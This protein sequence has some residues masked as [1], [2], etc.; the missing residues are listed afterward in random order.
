MKERLRIIRIISVL[1]L[2]FTGINALVAGVLFMLDPSGKK[3]GMSTAYLS[4]S[5]FS[6]F[7]IPGCILFLVNGVLAVLTAVLTIAEQKYYPYFIGAQGC[8]LSGWIIIQVILIH[9]F[10]FL[11][12]L[13]LGIAMLLLFSAFFIS[14]NK[15][16]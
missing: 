9:D 13:M 4:D 11:H 12:A 2:L 5:V 10:N 16:A 6:T 7:F 1:L 3:M 14:K 8:L 15:G